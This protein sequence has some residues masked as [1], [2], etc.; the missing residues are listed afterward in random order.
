[1]TRLQIAKSIL[2]TLYAQAVADA[3]TVEQFKARVF[4]A[5]PWG[6]RAHDPYRIWRRTAAYYEQLYARD[7]RYGRVVPAA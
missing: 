1:M 5:Y 6:E 7:V 4:D 2:S 3:V